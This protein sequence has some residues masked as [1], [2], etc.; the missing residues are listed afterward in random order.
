MIVTADPEGDFNAT[1][2]ILRYSALAREVTVPR[3]PSVTSQI[4]SGIYSHPDSSGRTSP[5]AIQEDLDVANQEIDRLHDEIEVLRLQLKK[6]ISRRR[7]AEASLGE[8]D[9]RMEDRM[10]EVEQRVREDCYQE[11]ESRLEAER[12]RW[13]GA[14]AE[15]ADRNDEHLDKKLDILARGIQIHEDPE[16]TEEERVTALE[17]Q[18]DDLRKEVDRLQRE[19]LGRSPTK[20][21]MRVLKARKWEADDGLTALAS[22]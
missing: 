1:S 5:S 17:Q 14:W 12:R 20:K 18:N 8:E 11:M 21:P 4:M 6:E 13:K 22:P 16:P 7:E 9:Q 2:Q 10:L 15:E 3:I 19:L